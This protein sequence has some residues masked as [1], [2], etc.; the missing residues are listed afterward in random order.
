[1]GMNIAS[2]HLLLEYRH[3]TVEPYSEAGHQ[4]YPGQS[5]LH[6]FIGNLSF[7]IETKQLSVSQEIHRISI[8]T[9]L[10]CKLKHDFN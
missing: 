6:I 1:M 9:A 3:H 10:R 7:E 4:I 2:L 5:P 8:T